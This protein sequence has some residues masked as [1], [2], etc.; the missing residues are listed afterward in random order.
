MRLKQVIAME[1]A[2]VSGTRDA[3]AAF[4][5]SRDTRE[6]AIYRPSIKQCRL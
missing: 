2:D 1:N 3:A 5:A 6:K 4:V